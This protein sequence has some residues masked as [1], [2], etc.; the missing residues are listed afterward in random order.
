MNER[1]GALG[2]MAA[3]YHSMCVFASEREAS[4][5][6][7]CMLTPEFLPGRVVDSAPAGALSWR[8]TA[9]EAAPMTTSSI[10]KLVAALAW[11]GVAISSASTASAVA[12]LQFGAQSS[13]SYASCSASHTSNYKAWCRDAESQSVSFE[14]LYTQNIKFIAT[15]CSSGACSETGTVYT[16]FIYG[17]G[18][19]T[20]VGSEMCYDTGAWF[21]Q[22]GSC[23]C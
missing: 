7:V 4:R 12:V 15:S 5:I 9:Q 17:A 18:R 3:R 21:Y 14:T 20:A 11:G 13:Y 22:L 8:I 23:A 6:V 16:D 10:I 2:C 19:K 1:A